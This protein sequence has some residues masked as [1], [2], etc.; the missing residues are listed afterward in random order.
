MLKNF[1]IIVKLLLNRVQALR[2]IVTD[3]GPIFQERLRTIEELGDQWSDRP[4]R[5]LAYSRYT[6]TKTDLTP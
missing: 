6:V 3:L 4:V 5:T 1:R 2:K